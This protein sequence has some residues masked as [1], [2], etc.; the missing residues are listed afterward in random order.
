MAVEVS[1]KVLCR[2]PEEAAFRTYYG[3]LLVNLRNPV[4]FAESLLQEGVIDNATKNRI[5]SNQDDDQ[6]RILLDSLQKVL[7]Q[8]DRKGQVLFQARSGMKN[9]GGETYWFDL[10]NDFID[11]ERSTSAN[12]KSKL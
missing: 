10:M 2:S 9:S 4:Q 7:Y 3:S 1:E 6:K 11:G 12:L 8:S 5:T